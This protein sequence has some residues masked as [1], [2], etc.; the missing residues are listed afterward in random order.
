MEIPVRL[1]VHKV[2]AAIVGE[3]ENIPVIKEI[4]IPGSAKAAT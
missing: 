2:K 1:A 3:L 4:V